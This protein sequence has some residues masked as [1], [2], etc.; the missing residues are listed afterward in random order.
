MFDL[1]FLPFTIYPYSSNILSAGFLNE[2][3]DLP[4]TLSS[5]LSDF[6][7]GYVV[8]S[9]VFLVFSLGFFYFSS[10]A[11]YSLRWLFRFALC[12]TIFY[13]FGGEGLYSDFVV[14]L[15][16]RLGSERWLIYFSFFS[17]LLHSTYSN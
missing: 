5:R 16:T 10:N 12:F 1:R 15:F 14:L 17:N 4:T 13:F 11:V 3:R 7:D 9:S 2:R 6:Y 8:F